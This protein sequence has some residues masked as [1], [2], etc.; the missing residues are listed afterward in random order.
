M[1]EIWKDIKGYED[2]YEISNLGRVRSKHRKVLQFC[3]GVKTEFTY[4]GV[5]LKPQLINSGY[6]VVSLY[7]S[8]IQKKFLV[9][10]LV[11]EA[12]LDNSNNLT[13]INH[14]DEDKLNNCADNLEWCSVNYNM[15]Y[16]NRA[17]KVGQKI[18]KK[19]FV[20][21]KNY[22]QINIFNSSKEASYFLHIPDRGIR[23]ACCRENHLY[24][25]YIWSYEKLDK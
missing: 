5:L 19:I 9:H 4:K 6:Y 18:G 12:H 10:R 16:N 1:K 21:D 17:K 11:A 22:K 14:K 15:T 13:Q 24:K 25:N 7:K 23:K 3:K 20:Y 2:C 8:S